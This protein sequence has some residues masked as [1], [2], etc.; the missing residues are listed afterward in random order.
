M[1]MVRH[2]GFEQELLSRSPLGPRRG[3]LRI[4]R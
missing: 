2:P 4:T 3:R 1:M